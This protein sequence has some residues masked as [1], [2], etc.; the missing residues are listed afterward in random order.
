MSNDTKETLKV[1]RQFFKQ[2]EYQ[3]VLKKCKKILKDDKNNYNALIL[4]AA[5]MKELEEY[6]SQAPLVLEKATKIEPNNLLAW[7][8]LVAY[9]EKN[10]DND[11]CRN[12]LISFYCKLL[13]I[14]SNFK[15]SHTLNRILEVSL[16]LDDTAVLGHSIET[17][18]ELRNKL[19]SD[20]M[21]L[22]NVTLVQLLMNNSNSSNE[23]GDLLENVLKSVVNDAEAIN[24]QDYYRK[25]LD[26]LYNKGKL[27]ALMKEA[28]SM[29]QQFSE[30]TLP[31]VYICRVY[32]E[33][34]ILDNNRYADID[35]KQFY[36]SLKKLNN[37]SD[38]AAIAHAVYLEKTD[39]L[40]AARQILK[41][42]LTLKPHM[43]YCWIILGEINVRL[44]CWEDAENA[45]RQALKLIKHEINDELLYKMEVIMM[46]SMSRSNNKQKWET[47][48]QMCE[49]Y[50]QKHSSK[51]VELICARVHVLLNHADVSITLNNLESQSEIKIQA[52][53]LKALYLKQQKLLDQ[54]VDILDSALE[55]SEA[56][57]ILGTIY[58]ELEQYNDSLMAFL[59]GVTVDQYNWECLVYLGRY[60]HEYG[61]DLERS[62]R[63]Y[64]TALQINPS[65]EQ[66]GIGLSTVYRLLKN[67]DANTQLLERLTMSDGGPKWAWLQLGRQYLDQGDALQA[68]KAFQR[69]IRADP[70]DNYNWES[71]GD[72]YFSRGAHTSALR[73]YQRALKLC[74]NSLY[75]LIQLANIKLMLEQYADA[76][77]DFEEILNEL[78]YV[79]V[80][81]GLA[82][83]CIALAKE[84]TVK[85]FLGRAN[86]YFQQAINNLSLAI[87]ERNN[88]SCLWKLL[89]DVCYKVALMPDKY[90]YL[91][92]PSK[93]VGSNDTEGVVL[94]KKTELSLLST[95]CCCCALSLS[96][97]SASLWHDLA[98]CYLLQLHLASSVDH[99]TLASKCLAAG[100][101]AVKLCPSAWLYWNLLGVICMSPYIRNYALAQHSYVM[102]IDKETNNAIVWCNLGT[103]YLYIGDLYKANEAY[104]QAQR[105]DPTY[106]NS[107]I[108]QALIAEMMSRKEAID[109]FR[110]STQLGY[111]DE[112]ALGYAHWV[113]T[114]LLDT[115]TEKDS[116]YTYIIENMHA[117]FVASDVMHWYLEHHPEDLYARNAY[118]LLLERQKL[119]RS[120][121]EQFAVAVQTSVNEE[122]DMV[123]LNLGRVL[124]QLKKYTEAV[125]FCQA[126]RGKA[127]YNSQCH[128]ALSLFKAKRYEE[129]YSTYETA[130]H[131]CANTETEK[132]YALCA[133]AAIAYTFQ[134]VHDAKTLLFQSIQ[135]QPPVVTSF[136]AAASL[137]ILHGD[138]NLTTLI[139]NELKQYEN[140]TDYAPHVANLRAY[141]YL[142]KNDVKSAVAT[143]SKAIFKHPDDVRYWIRLLRILLEIDVQSFSKCA[144]KALFLR[145]NIVDVDIVHI[146]CASSFNYFV[147][148][149]M[150]DNTRSIQKLLFTYP[151]RIES[152]STFV[153]AFLSRFANKNINCNAQWLLAFISVL[154]QS[155]QCTSSVA[156]WLDDSKRKLTQFIELR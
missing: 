107:W 37:E 126:V 41:N 30:D 50:L 42:I 106:V 108:G 11:E 119:Y 151:G 12:K 19:D 89:G 96:P 152:W 29:Y 110:H 32:Y 63:C 67:H 92:I 70:N 116:L 97:Q 144:Q 148:T 81:K 9:Y 87:V 34:N 127:D 55:V 33:Q 38:E 130:L 64:L 122:K 6:K 136:V 48:L 5:A 111:H 131:S 69:V 8:G 149:S 77:K 139:L 142:I 121:A 57:F 118:G 27:D 39:S 103:L 156:K 66:A 105:A 61:N 78:R 80:L 104:S 75:S 35:V 14:D 58:W 129:S 154:Q 28:I 101:R 10:L 16:Q 114:V 128:L 72:A 85:Q 40:I 99:K 36:E 83:A 68:I 17:L 3:E 88:M 90:S 153:A 123:C 150:S 47:A 125:T 56:W 155:V 135:I 7:Q 49:K 120:A 93:L 91:N 100:K 94:M 112:A 124:I 132:A 73:S 82:E 23:Y 22:F 113:L 143:L 60:Y 53:I 141:F 146:A 98:L 1:A 21:K 79:P 65:S 4:L 109:L 20:Q 51:Q 137:G 86:D 74:P 117:V 2:N 59:N 95:R 140:D 25:Y 43:L 138:L 134:G 13:Q 15:F 71:L 31:L 45:M 133:M 102:A 145:R 46:D 18:C 115:N 54:A 26:V 24:R 44:Y 76:K 147:E 52:T 62:R 84:S